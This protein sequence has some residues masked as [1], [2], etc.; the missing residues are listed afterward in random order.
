M[1]CWLQDVIDESAETLLTKTPKEW[2]MLDVCKWYPIT[3]DESQ[4]TVLQ[5]ECMRYNKLLKQ[6]VSTLKG[7]SDCVA[8]RAA[9]LVSQHT[10][11]CVRAHL[12]APQL[13]CL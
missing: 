12:P 5:Q 7:P 2:L 9:P 8:A 11:V 13:T 6:M 4:N 1:L 10:A 3:Y